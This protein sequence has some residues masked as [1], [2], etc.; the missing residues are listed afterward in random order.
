M[1]FLLQLT[2]FDEWVRN[3]R[4]VSLLLLVVTLLLL[5][6]L[7]GRLQNRRHSQMM[8]TALNDSARG[9]IVCPEGAQ[10]DGFAATI[11]PA[12]EPFRQFTIVYH[13]ASNLNLLGWLLR[14]LTRHP[15]QLFIRGSLPDPPLAEL[16]W[17]RGGIP[18]Y[19]LGY[20]ASAGLWV[21]GWLDITNSEYAT[22]GVN[23]SALVHL[24]RDLQTRF[25]PLLS[26]VQVQADARPEVEIV[27]RGAGLTR[28]EIPALVATIRGIGR[29]ALQR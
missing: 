10:S 2:Q 1:L 24:F 22:R 29:A 11:Q 20:R 3:A 5:S 4:G 28:E 17:T 6:W 7:V 19:A 25:G 21:Q 26:K 18:G 13:A 8:L 12:P 9:Q 14:G 23:P 16:I 15:D 27:L